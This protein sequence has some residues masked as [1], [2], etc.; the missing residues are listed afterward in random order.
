M[1][2]HFPEDLLG[3]FSKSPEEIIQPRARDLWDPSLPPHHNS[4]GNPAYSHDGE[5]QVAQTFNEALFDKLICALG[6]T[7]R[8]IGLGE[9]LVR[10]RLVEKLSLL[11]AIFLRK[12][13]ISF[14]K[15][16]L[17]K[18]LPAILDRPFKQLILR[19]H[20]LNH[21]AVIT[22]DPLSIS[23]DTICSGDAVKHAWISIS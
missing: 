2:T 14:S 5:S 22:I 19:N 16:Y 9:G 11:S 20:T 12:F 1:W 3:H 6:V 8:S 18:W 7:A 10:D 23:L 15:S 17:A 21:V 4:S 13:P